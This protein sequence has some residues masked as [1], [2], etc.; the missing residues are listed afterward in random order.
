MILKSNN[1]HFDV[2]ENGVL[3][4]FDSTN[5]KEILF[6]EIKKVN[7]EIKTFAPLYR[8]LSIIALFITAAYSILSLH[9]DMIF[10]IG[11]LIVAIITIIKNDFKTYIL[12]INLANGE[13]VKEKIPSTL[14]KAVLTSI[15][16]IRREIFNDRIYKSNN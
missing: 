4:N 12:E 6:S 15:Y 3:I 11:N 16:D 9:L 13:I 2:K 8:T 10:I 7:I 14:K 1:S 5:N